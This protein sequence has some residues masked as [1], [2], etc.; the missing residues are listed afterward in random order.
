MKRVLIAG[1]KETHKNYVNALEQSG[2][3]CMATLDVKDCDTYDF[4]ALLLPGGGDM[5]PDFYGEAMNGSRNPNRALDEAQW[6]I[7]D[8]FVKKGKTIFGIC[9]GHQLI[10]VYFG[11]SLIQH[12]DNT[13]E[14]QSSDGD[15]YHSTVVSEKSF[16][17]DIYGEGALEVNSSH[18]QAVKVL[19]DGLRPVQY[20]GDVI[21]AM[22]H[23]SL[24]IRSVQWHPE[25]M[26]NAKKDIVSLIFGMD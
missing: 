5:D 22:E 13:S 17:S 1:D 23:E 19:G 3:W 4:D 10:N 20:C 16:L 14:H 24:P 21:E 9:R 11:G 15:V 12:L 18:H 6:A 2:A 25:R 26:E 8:I 7:L